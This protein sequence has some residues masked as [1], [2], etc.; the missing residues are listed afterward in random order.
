MD[1]RRKWLVYMIGYMTSKGWELPREALD[2]FKNAFPEI[3]QEF[4]DIVL[5]EE[6]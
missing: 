6:K 3:P 1:R 2:D 5:E 4:I